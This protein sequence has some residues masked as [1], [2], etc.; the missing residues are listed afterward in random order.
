V[1]MSPGIAANPY[2]RFFVTGR[3]S[4]ALEF[5]WVDDAGVRGFAQAT[6]NVV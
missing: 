2:L 6:V 1:R 4:G 3:E 5:E